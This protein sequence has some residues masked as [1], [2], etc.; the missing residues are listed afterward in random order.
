MVEL[1]DVFA[2]CN[3]GVNPSLTTDTRPHFRKNL[4][5]W[6]FFKNGYKVF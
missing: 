3:F 5:F 2:E 4:N 6:Q 1:V